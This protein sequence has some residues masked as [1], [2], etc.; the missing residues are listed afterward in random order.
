MTAKTIHQRLKPLSINPDLRIHA[1][2][3]PHHLH[4]HEHVS[5]TM[6]MNYSH[7]CINISFREPKFPSKGCGTTLKIPSKSTHVYLLCISVLYYHVFLWL[8]IHKA[9]FYSINW[10]LLT[11]LTEYLQNRSR[12][13]IPPLY[14]L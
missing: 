4:K 3:L 9:C 1:H 14:G 6:R 2:A 8:K 13:S 11:E 12:L 5:V 7:M 10:L